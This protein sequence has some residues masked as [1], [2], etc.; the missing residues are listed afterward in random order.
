MLSNYTARYTKISSGYLGQL[1]EW[2]EVI[3]EGKTLEECREM[4][5]DALREMIL[6]YR[7]Q[8]KEIPPGGALLEQVPVE[9]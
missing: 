1:V 6:A 4:L 9:I 7:Q 5:K 3:T 2:P 8:K